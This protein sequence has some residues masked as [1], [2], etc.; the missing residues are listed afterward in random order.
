MIQLPEETPGTESSEPKL[1]RA[2]D[3][4]RR[5]KIRCAGQKP[6]CSTC[7]RNQTPCHYSS[8]V[9]AKRGRKNP[10]EGSAPPAEG[11]QLNSGALMSTFLLQSAAPLT[12]PH[13]S[14]APTYSTA[15]PT[16]SLT[17]PTDAQLSNQS[18]SM[19]SSAGIGELL[20]RIQS[21]EQYL[22]NMVIYQNQHQVEGAGT[23]VGATPGD[24]IAGAPSALVGLGLTLGQN[25]LHLSLNNNSDTR[26]E[27]QSSNKRKYSEDMD[28]SD[29]ALNAVNRTSKLRTLEPTSNDSVATGVHK[30]YEPEV[31]TSLI[32]LFFKVKHPLLSVF[33][34]DEFLKRFRQDNISDIFLNSILAMASRYSTLPLVMRD[35][36]YQAGDIYHTRART[37]AVSAMSVTSLDN[38]QAFVLMGLYEI[39]R[40]KE[41]A[42]MYIGIAT[43][44]AQRMGLNRID[45]DPNRSYSSREW[46][47]RET[48]RRVWWLTFITENLT[49][50]AMNRPPSLHP[51]DCKVNHPSS[52]QI[53]REFVTASHDSN[54]LGTLGGG[55]APIN[56]TTDTSSAARGGLD[57]NPTEP[58]CQISTD[59]IHGHGH[60]QRTIPSVNLT[61]FDVELVLIMSKISSTRSRVL[62]D[63]QKWLPNS[64]A[65]T[66]ELM[67]WFAKLPPHLQIPPGQRWS[68]KHVQSQ[69]AFCSYLINLH[70]L[71]YTAV[72]FTN[73]VD[74]YLRSQLTLDDKV[75]LE[76]QEFCWNS[77]AAI[78]QLM[79]LL[80][81]LGAQYY[82]SFFG[83]CLIN[84]GLVFIDNLTPTS[85]LPKGQLPDRTRVALSAD[86][87][88]R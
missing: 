8:W 57:S 60:V 61:S 50:L 4:C 55:G 2:C 75:L 17:S 46:Q 56:I 37:L 41:T 51:D 69:P 1:L 85:P 65:L 11:L 72:I 47:Q 62:V 14:N 86:Y 20:T 67:E 59:L 78:A 42:W 29:N 33:S 16:P 28:E 25:Q 53:L 88:I 68:K 7:Q 31:V 40:G 10:G 77:A 38:I 73:Q 43:R 52:D 34:Y 19:D 35:P 21:L 30:Y 26:P 9:R 5:K 6:V 45:A 58:S 66:Q 82:N 32:E 27:Q 83:M 13:P 80:E 44:M 54:P 15:L 48:K 84:A 79:D 64:R 81:H 23:N 39:G 36:P 12:P 22:Q 74:D 70:C 3:T 76:S 71:Y 49:S 63:P 24:P 87:L 18:L